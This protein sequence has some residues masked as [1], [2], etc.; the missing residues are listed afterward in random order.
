MQRRIR[1]KP[2]PEPSKRRIYAVELNIVATSDLA[3]YFSSMERRV[4]QRVPSQR[5]SRHS[6]RASTVTTG[7]YAP[8]C[9]ELVPDLPPERGQKGPFR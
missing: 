5:L 7:G 3:Q 1:E 6:R 8:N 4:P 9:R 2:S